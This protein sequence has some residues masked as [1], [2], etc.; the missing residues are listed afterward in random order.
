MKQ[1][2]IF[3]D[4]KAEIHRRELESAKSVKPSEITLRPYQVDSVDGVFREFETN[5][6]TLVCLPTG[7][8]KS[9][10][11]SEVMRRWTER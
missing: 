10:V 6:S 2:S 4:L 1:L 7:T 8:G 5:R 11:F 3:D 9:V